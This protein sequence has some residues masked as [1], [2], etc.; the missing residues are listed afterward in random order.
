MKE[1]KNIARY[2]FYCRTVQSEMDDE[3]D[4]KV[5][6]KVSFTPDVFENYH[7]KSSCEYQKMENIWR[8]PL[9]V[10]YFSLVAPAK[11]IFQCCRGRMTIKMNQKCREC[12]LLPQMC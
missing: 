7:K 10:S 5:L 3:N 9:I 6:R 12:Q 2:V 11:V 4:T 8:F 1:A